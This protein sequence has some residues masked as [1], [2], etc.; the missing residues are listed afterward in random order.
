MVPLN[1]SKLRK[2]NKPSKKKKITC[3]KRLKDYDTEVKAGNFKSLTII[4]KEK[5]QRGNN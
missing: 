4:R 1:T 2:Y 3:Q 5:K